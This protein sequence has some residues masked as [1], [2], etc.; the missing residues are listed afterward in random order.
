MKFEENLRDVL[1][2]KY[3][4]CKM[5]LNWGDLLVRLNEGLLVGDPQ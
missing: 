2:L 5:R 3:R 4:F 1:G